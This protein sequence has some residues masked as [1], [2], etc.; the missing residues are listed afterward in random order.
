MKG[1]A[2]V[3]K[4]DKILILCVDRDD[5]L[6][7]KAEIKTPVIGRKENEKAV[8]RLAI[9]DPEEAD[10]NA[11]F[12]AIK[13]YDELTS[14]PGKNDYQVATIAG[15]K[16]GGVQADEKL[17]RELEEVLGGFKASSTILVSD[18][19][20]DWDVSPIVSSRLPVTSVKRIVIR[21]SRSME[22]SW[23]ILSRYVKT[24]LENPQYKRL[25]LG[26]PG[27]A[28]L[29]FAILSV[30]NLLVYATAATLA[31]IGFI[32]LARGFDI[33]L[34]IPTLPSPPRQ[35]V[36]ITSLIGL[37]V[38]V[39][40][41]YNGWYGATA[42]IPPESALG[43][44]PAFVGYFV[45]SSLSYIVIGLCISLAGGATYWTL[46][47]SERAWRSVAGIVITLGSW[48]IIEAMT[49]LLIEPGKPLTDLLINS[50]IYIPLMVVGLAVIYVLRSKIKF[51]KV[52]D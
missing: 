11:M 42:Q 16:L 43:S 18:G 24:L 10:S 14:R 47:R 41:V 32:L 15:S 50:V 45:S 51:G 13:L 25:A 8:V 7:V 35:F 3:S 37:S 30:L 36:V 33:P 20:T 40:G 49:P 2:P 19:Y 48:G 9:K 29:V 1:Q 52:S 4:K 27:A 28:L 26:V 17:A 21:H 22:L 39:V 34:R 23:A 6:G 44:L 46:W 31:L 12:A 5:D 38:C